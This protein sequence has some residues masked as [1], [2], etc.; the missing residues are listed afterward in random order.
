MGWGCSGGP[1]PTVSDP[2]AHLKA[3][4]QANQGNNY[5]PGHELEISLAEATTLARFV[6]SSC[7]GNALL[8]DA[9]FDNFVSYPLRKMT[10][11]QF[12]NHSAEAMFTHINPYWTAINPCLDL[13]DPRITYQPPKMDPK[14]GLGTILMHEV[15]HFQSLGQG[16]WGEGPAYG[17]EYYFVKRLAIGRQADMMRADATWN[18]DAKN[19]YQFCKWVL[20]MK[21]CHQNIDRA[22]TDISAADARECVRDFVVSGEPFIRWGTNRGAALDWAE[23]EVNRLFGTWSYGQVLPG[24]THPDGSAPY[25]LESY[26]RIQPIID[27]N[28]P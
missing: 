22:R 21:W 7:F 24:T 23:A 12:S 28:I 9:V 20:V 25:R 10:S 5:T 8:E 19:Q 6:R 13:M 11:G 18:S 14:G 2:D 1:M 26:R 15:V 3:F 16:F 4:L 17:I 27:A